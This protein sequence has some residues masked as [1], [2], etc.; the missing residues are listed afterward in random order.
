MQE[1]A[2]PDLVATRLSPPATEGTLARNGLND[3]N[4]KE[5]GGLSGRPLFRRATVVLARVHQ[6]MQGGIPLI[7]IGG[8][9]SPKTALEKIEAG[10]T[11]IQLYT[12][13]IYEGPQL[14]GSIK[15]HLADTVKREGATSIT[16]LTGRRAADWA[17]R[18]PAS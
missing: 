11:L 6:M 14:I 18:D 4:R 9:D 8:I 3:A 10:A 2:A 17:A 1:T 16:E 5:G 15:R 7:G 12:G 13:L